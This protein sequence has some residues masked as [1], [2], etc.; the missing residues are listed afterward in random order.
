MNKRTFLKK[1]LSYYKPY[2]RL[3]F[4]DI[5]CS[6][7]VAAAALAFPLMIRQVTN[8]ILPGGGD[9]RRGLWQMG[10][11]MLGLLLLRA[12]CQFFYDAKGHGMGAKMEA[13]MRRALFAHY[14]KLS[15]S[16]HDANRPGQLMTRITNDLLSLAELYHHGPENAMLYLLEFVG[17]LVILLQINARLTGI[18]LVFLPFLLIYALFFGKKLKVAY[19]QNFEQISEVN[20]RVE[21]NL[22]GIRAVKAFAAEQAEVEKFQ[23][24]NRKFLA[25]RE[26]IYNKES[27]FYTGMDNLANLIQ[28]AVVVFGGLAI[29][30][31]TLQ[32]GDLLVFLL[33][34]GYLLGPIPKLAF[35][36][37]QFQEGITGFRR[38][39]EIMET[40]PE[41]QDCPNPKTP[42]EVRGNIRFKQ[43]SFAYPSGEEVLREIDL[44]IPAGSYT[45]LVGAS[46]VGKTTLCS[47]IP[48][49][50]EVSRGKI[51]LDGM[52]IREISQK[53][54]RQSIGIVQQDSDLFS[55]TVMENILLGRPGA[56]EQEAVEAARRANAHE[57]ILQLPQGY[58][59]EIGHRGVK[60]SGGQRQRLS[61]ARVFLKNPP[62][63]IFDEAT[64]ALDSASENA[65]QQAMEQFARN[66]TTLLIAHRLSTIRNAQRILVLEEGRIAESGNHSQ[67]LAKRGA[68]AAFYE[69]QCF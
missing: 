45:A 60:L 25:G 16:F 68:Y 32:I 54:L 20:A 39:L 49:F 50:Y 44:D 15:L 6:A 13:D 37:Q 63:L 64:S 11:A 23:R 40:P 1:L 31:E 55:G 36:T 59:T 4:M 9:I 29:V 35:L 28:V 5:L 18:I 8:V 30:G 47:L 66:R 22:S 17:A 21:E 43:V 69:R 61:I 34:V 12:A 38:F 48:R 3:F 24:E 19:Q 52:D 41:I 33:Y 46:G 65:V 26:S 53:A 51:L 2:K 10:L 58:A 62:I 14:Q 56:P 57:F 27:L 67:L 7:V 42:A